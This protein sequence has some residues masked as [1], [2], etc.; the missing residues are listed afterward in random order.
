VLNLGDNVVI[1]P[2][3]GTAVTTP[4]VTKFGPVATYLPPSGTVINYK[5]TSALP[6]MDI[7][8]VRVQFLSYDNVNGIAA[9]D[10]RCYEGS[11]EEQHQKFQ[12]WI[13]RISGQSYC[14]KK[15]RFNYYDGYT[16]TQTHNYT[17]GVLLGLFSSSPSQL[18]CTYT[19]V[20]Q[21][22]DTETFTL[23]YRGTATVVAGGHSYSCKVVEMSG[24]SPGDI[25]RV[26]FYWAAGV[27][28]VSASI[29]PAMQLS[30]NTTLR[31]PRWT[32]LGGMEIESVTAGQ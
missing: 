2:P 16:T 8:R 3:V 1:E 26:Q 14:Y 7:D 11:Y 25:G 31:L 5:I 29:A 23:T 18:T 21:G 30:Q 6:N 4:S 10:L 20:E 19:Q 15:K 17:P 9:I 22:G 12:F 24:W 27:G 13:K 28:P 32:R